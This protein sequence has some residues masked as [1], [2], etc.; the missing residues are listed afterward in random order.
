MSVEA[1][2]LEEML[3]E[4][5]RDPE[6][7][8]RTALRLARRESAE[9][10]EAPAQRGLVAELVGREREFGAIVAAW[11]AVRR[12]EPRH[13]HITGGAG[14]GKSRLLADAQTRLKASGTRTVLVR[15]APGERALSYAVA[16]DLVAA[17][18]PRSGA[19]PPYR[20][21]PPARWWDSRRPSRRITR[22]PSPTAPP[23]TS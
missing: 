16:A 4:D 17:L 10:V 2:Q 6:P 18:A 8:T 3:R 7:A 23:A 1:D 15:A 22:P 21:R 20:R 5:G 12:G 11:E 19:P 9:A 13:V 14:L